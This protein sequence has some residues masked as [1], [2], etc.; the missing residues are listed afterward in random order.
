MG[1]YRRNL[2]HSIDAVFYLEPSDCVDVFNGP[3]CKDYGITAHKTIKRK[4]GLSDAELPLVKLNLWDLED[5][6]SNH[7]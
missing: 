4:Y 3:K 6:F 7:Y 5:P 2:P 1:A